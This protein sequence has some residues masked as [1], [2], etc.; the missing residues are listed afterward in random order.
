VGRFS[1]VAGIAFALILASGIAQSLAA[2]DAWSQL[3]ETAYGRAV[4][5]KLG[6]FLAL[7]GFGAVNRRRSVP[8][9]RR[10]AA[11]D[12][13]PGSAGRGLLQ[14]LRGELA[15][16][17]VVLAI[18]GALATYPP[19]ESQASG[20]YSASIPI[21]PARAEVTVDPAR[22]G[23]NEIHLYLFDRRTGAQYNAVKE[24]KAAASLPSRSVSELPIDLRKAGPGHY[25]STG[26]R[27][28]IA[29]T[30]MLH[31]AAR[32]SAFD[33]HSVHLGVPIR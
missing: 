28:P 27:F 13:P 26:A 33:E 12:Q 31:L 23:P 15:L 6:L 1:T 14:L 20:P 18:T 29:G 5:L 3:T 19:G 11:G 17:I 16:G 30:W 7:V 24:M 25:V 4:L 10:A 9:L 2:I 22:V 21:G 8:A 32:V